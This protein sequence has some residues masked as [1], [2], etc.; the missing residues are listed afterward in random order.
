MRS[1]VWA[2]LQQCLS[3]DFVQN[4]MATGRRFR[5]LNIVDDVTR[6]CLA[7][8]PATSISGKRVIRELD[9]LIAIRGKPGMIVSDNSTGLTS[10]AL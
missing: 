7:A 6:E 5:V 2:L 10:Y 4:Q 3:L 9:A 8:V 1:P